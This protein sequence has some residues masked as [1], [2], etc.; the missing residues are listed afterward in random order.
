MTANQKEAVPRT[1]TVIDAATNKIETILG[2]LH[3]QLA[4]YFLTQSTE[5]LPA[6]ASFHPMKLPP[7]CLPNLILWTPGSSDS[8]GDFKCSVMGTTVAESLGYDL[9][10]KCLSKCESWFCR[11]R[12]SNLLEHVSSLPAI[13][14]QKTV[15]S[16][17]ESSFVNCLQS[18]FPL[19]DENN[20]IIKIV[21]LVELHAFACRLDELYGQSFVTG[22]EWRGLF[23]T[24]RDIVTAQCTLET[25]GFP[26]KMCAAVGEAK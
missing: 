17:G 16:L 6:A 25:K 21:M 11:T 4:R 5:Q 20:Q 8:G 12:F 9:T 24:L 19:L 18:A 13:A 10:Q 1:E 22:D 3:A 14:L 23:P 26:L 15:F 2:P 7:A